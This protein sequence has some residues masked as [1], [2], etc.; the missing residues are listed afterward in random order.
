MSSLQSPTS[1][2]LTLDKSFSLFWIWFLQL[3]Q[4]CLPIRLVG[5][6][7]KTWHFFSQWTH[8]FVYLFPQVRRKYSEM[9][10]KTWEIWAS[11]IH[12]RLQSRIRAYEMKRLSNR[13][14]QSR[15]HPPL[16][17]QSWD[18]FMCM[19]FPALCP[20]GPEEGNRPLGTVALGLEVGLS[21]RTPNT[22]TSEPSLSPPQNWNFIDPRG[23]Q[24][25]HY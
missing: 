11:I 20:W 1:L 6:K 10:Y 21:G 17:A 7:V 5:L 9:T 3:G 2:L 22:L 15:E 8:K 23:K 24:S 16:D 19:S 4:I 18:V 14:G 25:L 13:P 12:V